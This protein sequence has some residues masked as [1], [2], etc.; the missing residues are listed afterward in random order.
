VPHGDTA[1]FF[2]LSG[3]AEAVGQQASAFQ[4]LIKTVAFP[5]TAGGKPTWKL[6]PSWHE[7]PGSE[8]RFATLTIGADAA[9]D[10]AP[11]GP[12]AKPLEVSVTSLPWSTKDETQQLLANVNRWRGQ[13]QMTPVTAA[14]LGA[15]THSL[16]LTGEGKSTATLVDLTGHIKVGGMQPPFANAGSS[17]TSLPPGH[18]DMRGRLPLGHPSVSDNGLLKGAPL[19][20]RD[21][22]A[23]NEPGHPS[24]TAHAIPDD[25]AGAANPELPFTFS[26][27]K[28][29]KQAALPRFAVAAF[30][31]S[32]NSQRPEVTVTPLP[33][34]PEGIAANVNRWRTQ[35]ELKPTTEAELKAAVQPYEVD[36]AA[37]H[38]V[39]LLG[40]ED[41]N[42]RRAITAVVVPHDGVNWIFALKATAEVA[43][44]EQSDFVK[45]VSSVKF[46]GTDNK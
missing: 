36:G 5:K 4:S 40:P 20:P 41:S 21:T 18:P 16:K 25:T 37:G 11:G 7:K 12:A 14:E 28:G 38:L 19:A 33:S 15:Q 24:L 34:T 9:Q 46:R 13:M 23:P 43:K 35:L 31:V 32:E 42:P 10:A 8:M 29:W 1:W 17:T 3:P 30:A 22:A 39:R 27:P 2:K 26:T 44:S 45:F 6:P